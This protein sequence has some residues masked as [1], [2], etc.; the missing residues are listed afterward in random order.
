MNLIF[1]FVL[2]LGV[3]FGSDHPVNQTIVDE[4]KLGASCTPMEVEDNPF[5]Y[6]SF[7]EIQGLMG[8]KLGDGF[9]GIDKDEIELIDGDDF[10]AYPENFDGRK[11]FGSAITPVRDQQMCAACYAFG[12]ATAFSDRYNIA[13][14]NRKRMVFSPQDMISCST[15]NMGCTGGRVIHAWNYIKLAGMVEDRCDPYTSGRTERK[16]KCSHSCTDGTKKVRYQGGNLQKASSTKGARGMVQEGQ[17][18][19]AFIIYEDFMNYGGGV[20]QHF[21]GKFV[22]GH[23]VKI[24]GWGKENGLYY[25]LC[26]NSWGTKWGDRG[27]FKIRMGEVGINDEIYASNPIIRSFNEEVSE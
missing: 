7:E 12:A 16:G 13:S 25:W 4:I 17:V 5:A 15:Q 19:G 20:Y 27:Y 24:I 10:E 11:Q 6:W 14:G 2:I 8:T 22:G 18:E 9:D 21:S 26:A 3:T 1:R 23:A